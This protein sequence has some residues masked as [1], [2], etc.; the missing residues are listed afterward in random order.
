MKPVWCVFFPSSRWG[1]TRTSLIGASAAGLTDVL[2]IV[3]MVGGD[4][5]NNFGGLVGSTMGSDVGRLVGSDDGGLVGELV[6]CD[7]GVLVGG[8]VCRKAGR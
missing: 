7:E 6:D 1:T 5:G 3:G 2:P 4:V 8:Y